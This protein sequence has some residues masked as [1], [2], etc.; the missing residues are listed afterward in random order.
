MSASEAISRAC[1][2]CLRKGYLI[3]HLR[4]RIAGILGRRDVRAGGLLGLPER[5][6]ID[7]VAPKP[8]DVAAALRFLESFDARAARAGLA[9][10]GIAAVCGHCAGYPRGLRQLSDPPAALFYTGGAERLSELCGEPAVALVGTRSE[11]AYGSEVA[12]ALGGGLG[13]AGVTVVSGLAIGIDGAA[14]RG[15]VDAGGG[16]IA[17]LAGG[18]DV[19]YPRHNLALYRRIRETGI[20]ISELPPGERPMRWSFPARNRIMAALAG[21]T[22]VVEA[23]E[24]SGSLITASFAAQLGRTVAAV[25]GRVNSPRSA[26]S[27]RLLREGAAVVR[28][29]EDVL[30]ELFGVGCWTAGPHSGAP[31]PGDALPAEVRR[32]LDALDDGEDADGLARAAGLSTQAV[33]AALGRLEADGF[34]TRTGVGAYE[35]AL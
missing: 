7:T 31:S 28:G 12:R 30:D 27:N 35:R 16:A 13:A 15:C 1:E 21:V 6:L 29:P 18:V 5:A 19:P 20:V 10:A 25:P 3:G 22:V 2:A 9:G 23:A 4:G 8:A 32:V 14:H 33:R 11:S 26:G 17:V 34:I 24:R